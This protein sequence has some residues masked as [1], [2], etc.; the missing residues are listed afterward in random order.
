MNNE[1]RL[2]GVRDGNE[3]KLPQDLDA[4]VIETPTGGIYIDLSGPVP[5]CVLMRASVGDGKRVRLIFSPE[6]GRTAVGVI[7][8]NMTGAK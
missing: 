5:G 3:V 1:L 8:E 2:V 4:M 7:P 6:H